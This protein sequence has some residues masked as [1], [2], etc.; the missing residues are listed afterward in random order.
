[1][2]WRGGSHWTAYADATTW[3]FHRSGVGAESNE[4][5]LQNVAQDVA[6][7]RIQSIFRGIFSIYTIE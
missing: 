2:L 3:P 5:N 4:R 7:S 6:Q 1:M